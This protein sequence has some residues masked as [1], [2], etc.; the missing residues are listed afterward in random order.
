MYEPDT[1]TDIGSVVL[2]TDDRGNGPAIPL[3]LV[4][5][6]TG[7][8]IDFA[9]V[10]DDLAEDRRVV[11]WDHR[12]HSRLDQHRR[13]PR[14]TRSISSW[15]MPRPLSMRSRSTDSI[16]SATRW[17]ASWPQRFVLGHPDRVASLVLMD[18]LA[19]PGS[20]IPQDWMDRT[21]E[22][23]RNEGMSAVAD[24]VSKFAE[25]SSVAPEADRGRIAE[26]SRHKLSH[27]DVEAFAS[28]G[29]ELRTFPS[30]L[31]RLSEIACPTTVLVGELDTGLRAQSDAIAAAI[32]GSDL[33][34]IEGAAHCPQEERRDAWLAAVRHHLA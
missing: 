22:L 9:D 33:V 8:R 29:T 34:V 31:A 25:D 17:V 5:G 7:G 15:P 11:A 30:M 14:A 24:M 2:A 16:C 18:T 28:L 3:V 27:M 10:I 12:G 13:C 1:T 23:G 4:H 19:E 26:R 20:S 21:I 32:P 6:F